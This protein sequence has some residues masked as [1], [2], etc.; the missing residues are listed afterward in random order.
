MKIAK[1]ACLLMTIETV[2]G[3]ASETNSHAHSRAHAHAHAHSRLRKQDV[4][5]KESRLSQSFAT[6]FNMRPPKLMSG[7]SALPDPGRGGCPPGASQLTY[8][9]SGHAFLDGCYM[10]TTRKQGRVEATG[11]EAQH[12]LYMWKHACAFTKW[13]PSNQFMYANLDYNADT[14]TLERFGFIGMDRRC[15]WGA[16]GVLWKRPLPVEQILPNTTTPINVAPPQ[17]AVRAVRPPPPWPI[18][19]TKKSGVFEI[20]SIINRGPTDID[21]TTNNMQIMETA[22]PVQINFQPRRDNGWAQHWW[23]WGVNDDSLIDDIYVIQAEKSLKYWWHINPYTNEFEL[24]D[25]GSSQADKG[26]TDKH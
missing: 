22:S 13:V 24:K 11:E 8:T 18:Q 19:I 20:Q 14:M 15:F 1:V 17:K 25:A 16:I 3:A 9:G 2:M 5:E 23:F 12:Y 4:E 26:G 6:A 21:A 10:N 7:K